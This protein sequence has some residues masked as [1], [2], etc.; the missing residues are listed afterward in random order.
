MAELGLS[1]E[2]LIGH[3]HYWGKAFVNSSGMRKRRLDRTGAC[4]DKGIRWS[5]HSEPGDRD[6]LC[7]AWKTPWS[8]ICGAA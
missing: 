4:E 2:F 8:E 1:P 6:E 3:V 5:L 7:A